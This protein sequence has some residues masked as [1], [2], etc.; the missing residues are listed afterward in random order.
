MRVIRALAAVALTLGVLEAAAMAYPQFR[1]ST[2]NDRCSACHLA[3]EGGG[4]LNDYGRSEVGDTISWGGDGGLLHGAWTPP[5]W[6]A[7]GGD[8]RVAGVG[9][10]REGD[11]PT[12][13]AFPMQADLYADLRRG[14]LSVS[15]TGGLNGAARSRPDGAGP[16]AYLTSRRHVLTYQAHEGAPYVRVGRFFPVLGL[17]SADHSALARRALDMYILEEPYALG[18]GASGDGWE[19]HGSV[20][21]PSPWP[22]TQAGARATG[23]TVFYE[24]TVGEGAA[25][26][27][28]ARYAQGEL[29]RRVLVGTVATWW[30]DGPGLL[31]QAELDGQGQRIADADLTRWQLLGAAQLTRVMLPGLMIGV[32]GQ[33]WTPDLRLRGV[34]RSTAELDVQVFPWAHVELHLLA[35]IAGVGGRGDEPDLL[36]LV[37][38]HYYP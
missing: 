34:S 24:R 33:V 13:A 25:V 9:R 5:P 37:Q 1:F 21:A 19:L 12:L 22:E 15:I 26:A 7:L 16:A 10:L 38:V 17:R 36:G 20:F 23:A 29:D 31:L 27:G 8:V 11:E 32:G 3:P 18:A 6:L 35:R 14:P 30:L 28:Q 2:G 4:L